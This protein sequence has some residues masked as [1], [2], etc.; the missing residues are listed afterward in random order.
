M[1]N[2][3][4]KDI[5]EREKKKK[6]TLYVSTVLHCLRGV[7]TLDRFH[8]IYPTNKRKKHTIE[9][10]RRTMKKELIIKLYRIR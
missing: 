5:K 10:F 9:R 7:S 8:P 1:K 6:Q 3:F 4:E 2:L